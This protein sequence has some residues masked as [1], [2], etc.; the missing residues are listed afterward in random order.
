MRE[1][2]RL[3]SDRSVV[4]RGLT[5][6]AVAG[7]FLVAVNHGYALLHGDLSPR[8]MLAIAGTIMIPY[9]VSVASSVGAIQSARRRSIVT[10]TAASRSRGGTAPR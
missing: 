6:A 9:A 2:L 7:S 1:W 3:A 10:Q 5:V 4:R 8:R